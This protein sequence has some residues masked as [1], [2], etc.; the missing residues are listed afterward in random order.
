[1]ISWNVSP[2]IVKIGPLQLRWYGLM[3]LL[4]F[5]IGYQGMR[6]ICLWEKKALEKLDSLL[7][8]I[9]LGTLIG[10]RLG[11]CLFYEP[12]YYFSHPLDIFKVWE[13]GLA[14]HGG[15]LGVLL[16]IWLFSRKNPDF[17]LM[18]ILDRVAIFVVLTGAFIRIGNLMNSE[19]IG[20]PTD[21]DW[22]FVFERVDKLP[23]HPTQIYESLCYFI[24]ALLSWTTY[25]KYKKNLSPGRVFGMT[26]SLIFICRF[27]IEFFKENQESFEAAMPVNMGQLLSL[28]FVLVGIYF[29]VRSFRQTT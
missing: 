4:G 27:I 21:V 23:R 5:L 10:A 26:L 12:G 28:P 17:P 7:T 19:I 11:H 14:S 18:W 20:R 2:T 1:M 6:K 9:F 15:A 25:K 24:I 16:A 22:A 3:F 13:G 29:Y 8:H